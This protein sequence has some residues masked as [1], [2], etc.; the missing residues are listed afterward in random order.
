MFLTKPTED[1]HK[2][3][4]KEV[5]RLHMTSCFDDRATAMIL[6]VDCVLSTVCHVMDTDTWES[7]E[8]EKATDIPRR[9]SPII[10]LTRLMSSNSNY[11]SQLHPL[12]SRDPNE[13]KKGK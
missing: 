1:E 10:D 2:L 13:W 4:R 12:N 3:T 8:P 7:I 6:R 9:G 5:R 11:V